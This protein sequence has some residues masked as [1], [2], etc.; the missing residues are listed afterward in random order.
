MANAE[1]EDTTIYKAIVNN[2]EQ[3][4]IWPADRPI[5]LGWKEVGKSGLKPD[6]LAYIDE[7]ADRRPRSVRKKT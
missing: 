7:V 2:D 4:S 3:Y 6:V 5:P 1:G